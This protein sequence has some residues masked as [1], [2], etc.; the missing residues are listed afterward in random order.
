MI[1]AGNAQAAQETCEACRALSVRA[2]AWQCDVADY[3]AV[4]ETVAA[5]RAAFGGVDI[6]ARGE[7]SHPQRLHRQPRIPL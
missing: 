3:A 5:I 2:E 4:K 1:Y 7:D 6:L